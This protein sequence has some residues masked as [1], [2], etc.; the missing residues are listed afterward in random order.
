MLGRF[1]RWV[2]SFFPQ[3]R[4]PTQPVIQL[5]Q[6]HLDA[7]RPVAYDGHRPME[8]TTWNPMLKYPRNS[9][10]YCGS[11]IKAKKCCLPKQPLAIDKTFAATAKPLVRT[12][13]AEASKA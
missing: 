1:I 5:T 10:C 12:L 9:V 3:Y 13:R 7:Y 11:K 6:K 8:G 4:N 2:F